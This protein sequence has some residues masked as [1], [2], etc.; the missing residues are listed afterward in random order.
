METRSYLKIWILVQ[1]QGGRAFQTGRILLYFEDL[2]QTPNA[3][4]G[5]KD[6][7]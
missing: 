7:F 5:P 2:E 1:Y 6:F 3:D 4:I